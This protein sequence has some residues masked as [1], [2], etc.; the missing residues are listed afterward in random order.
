MGLVF[1]DVPCMAVH[2]VHPSHFCEQLAAKV[3]QNCNS[4][5]GAPLFVFATQLPSFPEKASFHNLDRLAGGKAVK[6][7]SRIAAG[8]FCEL[9]RQGCSIVRGRDVPSC[10]SQSSLSRPARVTYDYIT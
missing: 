3:L 9:W 7:F 1:S 6:D 8:S 5:R 10:Y 4:I 2:I